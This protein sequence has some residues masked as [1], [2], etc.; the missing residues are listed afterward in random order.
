MWVRAASGWS[1]DEVMRMADPLFHL[2]HGAGVIIS[3]GV[4]DARHVWFL[5]VAHMKCY[6][7][8]PSDVCGHGQVGNIS[9]RLDLQVL[10]ESGGHVLEVILALPIAFQMHRAMRLEAQQARVVVDT[11]LYQVRALRKRQALVPAA[12]EVVAHTSE[13]LQALRRSRLSA[14]YV[15]VSKLVVALVVMVAN[16][17]ADIV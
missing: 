5:K 2:G 17:A 13:R 4:V 8:A 7:S 14:G 15:E 1:E 6:R 11:F 10:V 9:G 16:K 3:R 12:L